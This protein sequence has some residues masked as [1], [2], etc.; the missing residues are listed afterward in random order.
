MFVAGLWRRRAQATPNRLSDAQLSDAQPVRNGLGG[1]ARHSRRMGAGPC[2]PACRSRRILRRGALAG[3]VALVILLCWPA[4]ASA[5]GGAVLTIH[6]D[7]RGSVW[8]VAQ[9]QD[10]HPITERIGAILTATSTAGQ[11]VGPVAL[12]QLN[13]GTGT[14]AYN[15]TLAAGEWSVVAEMASPL[16]GRCAATLRVTA[17]G[18]S[19]V[20]DQVRC[21]AA[22][23]SP[24]PA[25]PSSAD[26]WRWLAAGVGLLVLAAGGLVFY[27]KRRQALF[28]KRKRAGLASVR[29]GRR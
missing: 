4:A 17:S 29:K 8:V 11:R 16:L 1:M 2:P 22:P 9:Y 5:H 27:A 24:A 6:G 18:A 26:A 23:A 25:P 10:G 7:G 28:T 21:G 3:V 20:P 14:L 19:P 13:D 12:R 15:G